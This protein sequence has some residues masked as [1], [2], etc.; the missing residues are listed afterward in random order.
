MASNANKM[1][2]NGQESRANTENRPDPQ[3][4]QGQFERQSAQGQQ[5]Q[6]GELNRG[7]PA[8]YR[9]PSEPDERF[10]QDERRPATSGSRS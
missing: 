9:Q 7:G 3:I 5:G 6:Q 4:K 1:N 8:Q 10:G 2:T